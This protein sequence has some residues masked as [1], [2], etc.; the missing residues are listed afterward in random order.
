M[1]F[2]KD[3]KI[4]PDFTRISIGLAS[5]DSILERSYGEVLKPETIN[6]RTY[7]PERDGLFCER[8]FGPIKDYECYCGKYKRI[9]YKGI[10]CDRC[11]VEVTEKKVRRE[12]MGHIKLVVPVVHIWYFKSLPNKIGYLLGMSSKK[13][14]SIVYYERF[15]VIQ[16]GPLT[17]GI[18][19]NGDLKSYKTHDL[20]TEEEYLEVLETLPKENQMLDDSDPNKFIAD[21]GAPAVFTMLSRI[22]LDDLSAAL[23]HQANTETSQQ[24]KAEALKRLSVVEACSAKQLVVTKIVLN[25]WLFNIYR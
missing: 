10:V 2:K 13:L 25:G 8:I 6:Y 3:I 15:C 20:I 19:I 23:R 11:G 14:E 16:P 24:R 9:R 5:P 22:N 7:K 18:M 17:E 1:P 4:K 12:R 21:M